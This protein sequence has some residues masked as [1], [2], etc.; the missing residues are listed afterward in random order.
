M[1]AAFI[2]KRAWWIA[3]AIALCAAAYIAY[4][5]T[6]DRAEKRGATE[7]RD[8][9]ATV[10]FD[11]VGRANEAEEQFKRNPDVRRTGCLRHSRTPENC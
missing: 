11:R 8:A 1:I 7:Q 10:T 9:D 5:R 6:I 3:A 4:D 2:V